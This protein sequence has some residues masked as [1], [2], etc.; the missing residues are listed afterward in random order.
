MNC[1]GYTCDGYFEHL[2]K[3]QLVK[4]FAEKPTGQAVITGNDGARSVEIY[5]PSKTSDKLT[6]SC[7]EG[8]KITKIYEKSRKK[9][10]EVKFSDFR[11]TDAILSAFTDLEEPYVPQKVCPVNDPHDLLDVRID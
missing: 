9:A 8:V 7:S 4:V 10:R 2:P 6:D 5:V 11:K 3:D 1:C